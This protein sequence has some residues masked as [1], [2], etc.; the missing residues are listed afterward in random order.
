M[1]F[2]RDFVHLFL[3]AENFV[4]EIKK[5]FFDDYVFLLFHIRAITSFD[6]SGEKFDN[7]VE[8]SGVLLD[9][10]LI[11]FLVHHSLL[12]SSVILSSNWSISTV[13]QKMIE[14]EIHQKY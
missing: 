9:P 4:F 14:N 6:I 12:P 8:G 5:V 11:N 3:F 1:K 7:F 13:V 2:R 10:L